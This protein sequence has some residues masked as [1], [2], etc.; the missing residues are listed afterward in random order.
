MLQF[1]TDETIRNCAECLTQPILRQFKGR[2]DVYCDTCEARS[3]EWSHA[4]CALN[5]WDADMY[6]ASGDLDKD[7]V[8]DGGY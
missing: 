3:S 5:Q 1:D 4:G 2:F 6:E 7:V 8:R